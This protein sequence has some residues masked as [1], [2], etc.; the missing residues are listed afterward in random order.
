MWVDDIAEA[1]DD[2]PEDE[3]LAARA[4]VQ[5]V[6]EGERGERDEE[7]TREHREEMDAHA[8]RA[9]GVGVGRLTGAASA[10]RARASSR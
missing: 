4:A 6:A 1:G 10:G 8:R 9:A 2:A 7:E 3:A 5:A